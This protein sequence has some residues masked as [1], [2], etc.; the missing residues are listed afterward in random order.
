LW[1]RA[2]AGDSKRAS[3]AGRWRTEVK[4][5]GK[6]VGVTARQNKKGVSAGRLK[7]TA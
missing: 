7:R 6:D 2:A 4:Q 5:T 3:N 1:P